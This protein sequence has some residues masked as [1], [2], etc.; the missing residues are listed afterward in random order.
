[1]RVVMLLIPNLYTYRKL[2]YEVFFAVDDPGYAT[3]VEATS[4]EDIVCCVS[5]YRK[6][7]P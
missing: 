3:L 1:M 6:P 4:F 2:P 5:L 7:S